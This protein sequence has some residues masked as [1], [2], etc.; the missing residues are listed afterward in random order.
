VEVRTPFGGM[1]KIAVMAL[2][3]GLPLQHTFSC[4]AP[5][6]DLHCGRCNKCAE[7]RKAFAE[8]GMADP[9]QYHS[10]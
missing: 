5:V 1:G 2:G 9:T 4:I 10:D 7:R 6:G 3:N 8:A